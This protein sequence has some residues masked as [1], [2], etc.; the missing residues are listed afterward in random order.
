MTRLWRHLGECGWFWTWAA[1]GALGALSAISLGPLLA[2]PVMLGCWA[3]IHYGRPPERTLFGLATGTGLLFLLV[4]YINR[5]GPFDPYHWSCIG[6]ALVALGMLGYGY[7]TH[8]Y[9][10]A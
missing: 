8:S 6:I 9:H 4:A 7:A 5:H 1:L 10:A 2:I 3:V